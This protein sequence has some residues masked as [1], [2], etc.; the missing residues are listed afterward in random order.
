M[1]CELCG[2]Q[3]CKLC[4]PL[5]GLID[6]KGDVVKAKGNY[7]SCPVCKECYEAESK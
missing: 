4:R 5:Y 7:A 2:Q 1:K 3:I 6:R